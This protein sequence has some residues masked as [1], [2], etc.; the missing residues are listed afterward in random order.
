MRDILIVYEVRE[1]MASNM[2]MNK[3][4]TGTVYEAIAADYL[5]SQGYEILK[6]NYRCKLGEIDLIAR[7]ERYLVFIEVK[8][9]TTGEKGAAVAAV[10]Y[11]KQRIISRVAAFYMVKHR[12]PEDTPCRFDVVAIDG[13]KITLYKNAF[14]YQG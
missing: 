8:Y 5:R 14:E 10:D 4:K 13:G 6:Q 7:D 1:V 2:T 12:L 11:R 9:R 3:R